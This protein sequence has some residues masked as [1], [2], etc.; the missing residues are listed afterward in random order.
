MPTH[1][2]PRHGRHA[3]RW[4]ALAL[5][6]PCLGAAGWIAYSALAIPH[7]LPL[8]PALPGTRRELRG[9]VGRLSYYVAGE[10]PPLLLAHGVHAA[11]SAHDL[12]PIFAP[13]STTH[14]VYA[15]DLPGFGFSE[16]GSRRYDVRLYV[17][18]I[19]DLLGVMAQAHDGAPVDAL[20]AGLTCEVLARAALDQPRRLRTLTMVTPTGLKLRDVRAPGPPGSTQEIAGLEALL[21]A[22]PWG[23]A[24]FDLLTSRPALRLARRRGLG[25]EHIPA[26]L[27][28]YDY[29]SAHQPEAQRAPYAYLS[30]RLSSRDIRRVYERLTLP[31]WVA[32][33]TRGEHADLRGAG[34]LARR[35]NWRFRPFPTGVLPYFEQPQSF[36]E[37]L[38]TFLS[39]GAH[40]SAALAV[41]A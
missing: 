7:R 17:D 41:S 33:G 4:L 16:R 38:E 26:G 37:E 28:Q 24:L 2:R 40:A 9:R 19:H 13:L 21:E 10:G 22:R 39:A 29:A 11:A 12:E 32:H 31:V 20:A 1:V 15:P 14:C 5:A 36:L 18:A 30:G 35:A 27:L 34:A 25:F 6:A 8:P 3:A 23:R